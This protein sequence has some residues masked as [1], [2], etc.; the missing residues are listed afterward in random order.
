MI[1]QLAEEEP[2]LGQHVQTTKQ[3]MLVGYHHHNSIQ[4]HYP[5]DIKD[6][7]RDSD[8]ADTLM[9]ADY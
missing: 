4:L 9:A 5:D 7:N 6:I 3:V 8:K 2:P 1:E